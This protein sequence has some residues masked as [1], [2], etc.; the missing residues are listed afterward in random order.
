MSKNSSQMLKIKQI[1]K[2]SCSNSTLLLF[3]L[4]V[5]IFAL[6]VLQTRVFLTKRKIRSIRTL[7]SIEKEKCLFGGLQGFEMFP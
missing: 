2:K 6:V 5:N 1:F 4:D 3:A 7:S